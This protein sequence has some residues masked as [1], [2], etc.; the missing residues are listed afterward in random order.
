M[1]A[2]YSEGDRVQVT[3]KGRTAYWN[4]HRKGT[5]EGTR[6]EYVYVR[7]DGTEHTVN[8]MDRIEVQKVSR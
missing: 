7:W 5:V 6:S 2:N 3:G 8:Q 1:N 4:P